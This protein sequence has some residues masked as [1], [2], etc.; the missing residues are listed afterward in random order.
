M[1]PKLTPRE[2]ERLAGG[3]AQMDPGAMVRVT[4]LSRAH[5]VLFHET[6]IGWFL[7][8]ARVRL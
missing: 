5:H 1:A 8:C 6:L 7:V 2:R 4:A 3:G